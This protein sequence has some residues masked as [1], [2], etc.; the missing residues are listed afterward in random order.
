MDP[1]ASIVHLTSTRVVDGAPVKFMSWH[2]NE[3]GYASQM[4]KQARVLAG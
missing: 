3:S 4:V 1:R 2:D